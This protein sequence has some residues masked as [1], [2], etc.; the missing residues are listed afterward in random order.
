[1]G[2]ETGCFDA[3]DALG[4]WKHL[5]FPTTQFYRLECWLKHISS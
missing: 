2:Q 1:M 3:D 4:V 5:I